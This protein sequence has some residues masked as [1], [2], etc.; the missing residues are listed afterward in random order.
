MSKRKARN[1]IG[2]PLR[3]LAE[4][5]LAECGSG[6]DPI[7]ETTAVGWYRRM[8]AVADRIDAEHHR[9]M[10]SQRHNYRRMTDG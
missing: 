7:S 2:D 8:R 1:R 9:R 6:E 3:T 5:M 10:E 4:V